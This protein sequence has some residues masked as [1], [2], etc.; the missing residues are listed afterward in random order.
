MGLMDKLKSGLKD[1]TGLG[2]DATEQYQRAY[3]K[4]VYIEDYES[5][6]SC[7]EKAAEKYEKAGEREGANQALANAAIYRLV[8]T[9]NMELLPTVIEK[10]STIS[11]IEQ[12]FTDKETVNTSVW[13][14]EL[15]A[16]NE[17]RLGEASQDLLEK[18]D[19]YKT[20]G[21][22][23]LKVGAAPL[24]FAEKLNLDGPCDKAMIRSY[25]Y[26]GH[27]DH[28]DS[29]RLVYSVP[30]EA[31][32]AL[33]KS[34]MRFKQANET[35]WSD[36][37]EVMLNQ[38]KA[39]RHCWMCGREMQGEEI[40][41]RYYPTNITEYIKAQIQKNNEDAGM[42][43][44]EKHVTICRVCG[45]TIENQANHFA[46]MRAE[47]VKNW[48]TEILGKHEERMDALAR[49]L[50]NLEESYRNHHH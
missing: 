15:S 4:G 40:H 28:F 49:R 25:Y 10:L 44:R 12:L 36:K 14:D 18:R 43:D 3:I 26:A 8:A 33:Q 2:L 6:I 37:V 16:Y 38:V 7:F 17:A 45:L 50:S 32:N 9:K 23:M 31:E 42:L 24:T 19:R 47:E 35:E 27:A 22:L 30:E 20:A 39:K 21:D 13:I 48:A 34:M 46:K 29:H 11:E 41:F 1:A 5:A